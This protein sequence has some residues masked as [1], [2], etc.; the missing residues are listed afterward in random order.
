MT[1]ARVPGTETLSL[2]PHPLAWAHALL[3][4]MPRR[5]E[6]P[7]SSHW[8]QV[9]P[10]WHD[11]P[12]PGSPAWWALEPWDMHALVVCEYCTGHMGKQEGP[13]EATQQEG[14]KV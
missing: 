7:T 14:A 9:C 6:R 4:T 10:Q 2:H 8:C 11:C 12:L 5:G 13:K 1:V 3:W